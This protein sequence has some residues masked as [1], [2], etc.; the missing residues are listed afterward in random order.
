MTTQPYS[1]QILKRDPAT[2]FVLLETLKGEQL[3]LQYPENLDAAWNQFKEG[4]WIKGS[5]TGMMINSIGPDY[6]ARN[7]A[8]EAGKKGK[9]GKRY[10]I[11]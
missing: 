3:N 5:R 4:Y 1:G 10:G 9:G 11:S 6:E 2:R 8:I 7:A